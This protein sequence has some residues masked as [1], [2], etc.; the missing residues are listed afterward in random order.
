MEELLEQVVIVSNEDNEIL[1]RDK[2]I[3]VYAKVNEDGFI[4]DI[5]SNIFIE[6]FEGWKKIDEG[7]GDKFAHAQTN[8]FNK[9]IIDNDGNYLIKA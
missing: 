5:N 6:D 3:E 9:P 8:Y 4:T 1:E 2:T 7:Y